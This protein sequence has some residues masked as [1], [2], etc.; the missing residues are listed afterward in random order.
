MKAK[1]DRV[2]R[3][4]NKAETSER[5]WKS[6]VARKGETDMESEGGTEDLTLASGI[7]V[8]KRA[9]ALER[10]CGLDESDCIAP[11]GLGTRC[12]QSLRS[13]YLQVQGVF[14]NGRMT[15]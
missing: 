11:L 7:H 3:G 4:D 14:G 2:R 10:E 13:D 6:G 15:A 5:Q 8:D 12:S 9:S 1:D